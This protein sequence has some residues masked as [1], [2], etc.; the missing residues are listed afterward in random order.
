MTKTLFVGNLPWSV[1]DDELTQKFQE[2]AA[3]ISARVI[4]DRNTGKSRGFGFVEVSEDLA[5]SVIRALDQSEWEGRVIRVS[6]AQPRT[7]NSE[8]RGAYQRRRF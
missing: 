7:Q 2:V 4:T 6:E 8:R 1:T 3:V 5:E